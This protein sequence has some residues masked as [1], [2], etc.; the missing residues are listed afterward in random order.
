[1]E[2]KR[3]SDESDQRRRHL[4]GKDTWREKAECTNIT[5]NWCDLTNET[6]DYSEQYY[7]KVVM[8]KQ[9]CNLS[10]RF[11]PWKDTILDPPNINLF[12]TNTS[13]IINLTHV[14][15]NLGSIY[16]E[17]L[18][19]EIDVSGNI[20]PTE[21]PYFEIK[22]V[23]PQT[24]YCVSARVVCFKSSVFSNQTCITT[25]TDQTS[26]ERIKIILYILAVILL[27]FTVFATGY[28]VL[29]YIYVG[30]H[31]KPQIL[32]I[33]SSNNNNFVLVDAHNITINVITI[34]SRKSN[35]QS[36]TMPQKENKPQVEKDQYFTDDGCDASH[37]SGVTDNG[38]HASHGSGVTDDGCHASHGSGVTD[39]GY[40]ASH[41]SGVT[42]DG[43]DASHGSGVT[44]DDDHGYVSLLEEMPATKPPLSPYDMPQTLLEIPGRPSMASPVIINKEGDLYGRIKCNSDSVPIQKKNIVEACQQAEDTFTYLPKNDQH[45]PQLDV[46]NHEPY[47]DFSIGQEADKYDG[48]DGAEFSE[49]DTLFVDWSPTSHQ[50]YIPNFLNKRVDEAGTEECRE[51]EGLLSNLYKPIQIEKETSEE[52]A[53]LEQRWELHVKMQE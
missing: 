22:N 10:E 47:E 52:L 9:D 40:N 1:M 25:K 53:F 18:K 13:I 11:D 50:L 46:L 17:Y 14:V 3:E 33:T 51:E 24:T 44:H 41:G 35:E 27:L 45:L 31:Q 42:D 37:G 48:K 15:K 4:Y 36:T 43:Y 29:K 30:N 49:C 28:G 2:R 26:E 19:Y 32:N 38:C 5:Q 23:T 7:G 16:S 8:N 6:S 12:L 34:E 20:N 39:D 21:K